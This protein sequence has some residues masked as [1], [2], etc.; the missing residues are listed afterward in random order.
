MTGQQGMENKWTKGNKTKGGL[1]RT[2]EKPL[3]SGTTVDCEGMKPPPPKSEL[4]FPAP[5]PAPPS[6]CPPPPPYIAAVKALNP[7]LPEEGREEQRNE[8][9]RTVG[10]GEPFAS[11]YF[12]RKCWEAARRASLPPRAAVPYFDLSTFQPIFNNNT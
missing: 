6:Y 2:L 9:G 8:G 7:R 11:S 3:L 1:R 5:P 4:A 12:E 10:L